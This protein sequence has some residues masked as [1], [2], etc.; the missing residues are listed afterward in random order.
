MA[1]KNENA[2]G[3]CLGLVGLVMTGGIYLLSRVAG[4]DYMDFLP[5]LAPVIM[6]I[7]F[8]GVIVAAATAA[9]K[10]EDAA[11][12]RNNAA[13]TNSFDVRRPYD[14]TRRLPGQAKYYSP[15]EANRVLP[16]YQAGHLC[17][18]A[19]NHSEAFVAEDIDMVKSL[20]L[21][22]YSQ[23]DSKQFER[24]LSQDDRESWRATI[25]NLYRSGIINADEYNYKLAE[26]AHHR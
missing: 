4:E 24:P 12:R 5:F 22:S 6:I 11:K 7:V 21:Y 2:K 26:L 16:D 8:V 14:P 17:S 20:S 18:D 3:G 10:K 15:A 13:A 9:K 25:V 19:E 23:I 1:N